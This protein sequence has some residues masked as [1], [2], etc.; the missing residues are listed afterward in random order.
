MQSTNKAMI[1]FEEY[2]KEYWSNA[3]NVFARSTAMATA[4]LIMAA[5][6]SAWIP[7]S[8]IAVRAEI[9]T[10][11]RRIIDYNLSPSRRWRY[12]DESLKERQTLADF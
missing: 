10:G 3:V 7:S 1:K 12:I 11:Q 6:C 5:S 4:R 9:K 8:G 2:S